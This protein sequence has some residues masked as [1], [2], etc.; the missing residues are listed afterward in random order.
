MPVDFLSQNIVVLVRVAQY[1][2]NAHKFREANVYQAVGK[3]L[4]KKRSFDKR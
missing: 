3:N 2:I 1:A 4:V